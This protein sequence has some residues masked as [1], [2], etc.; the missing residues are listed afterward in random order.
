M[1]E[2]RCPRCG[3]WKARY[4]P[5]CGAQVAFVARTCLMCGSALE[6][7]TPPVRAR[8]ALPLPYRFVLS[9]LAILS[10]MAMGLILTWK[11]LP[12]MARPEEE[13]FGTGTPQSLPTATPSP[14]PTVT[15]S[16]RPTF[17]F[18]PPPPV[19][20]KVR[21]GE[22]LLFIAD[23][24]GTTV[25]AIIK[26]N[27]IEDPR[28]LIV[29]EEILIPIPTPTT[30]ASTPEAV[31]TIERE[32]LIHIVEP[33]ENPASIAAK[34]GT[35]AEALMEAND[36]TDP[37]SLRVGQELVIPNA[38]SGPTRVVEMAIHIVEPGDTLL[39]IAYRYD[40]TVEGIMAANDID[41]P[42]FLRVGQKLVIPLG[43]PT[44]VPT[45]TPQPTPTPTPGPP[46]AAPPLLFPADGQELHGGESVLLNWASVGFLSED[47]WYVVRLRYISPEGP[48][49]VSARTKAT[50]WLLPAS[51][52]P[53]AHVSSHLFRW[54]VTVVRQAEGED[55]LAVSPMSATRSFLWY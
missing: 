21:P 7:E 3:A 30:I 18:T 43:T 40:S 39:S 51:L 12:L 47:E 8:H 36:I 42:R 5:K 14:T 16:P 9:A 2:R 27:G 46:Y 44:P 41:D 13:A 24:Y 23:Y 19:I 1:R 20:H 26:A 33:G 52:R 34:Y 45:P 31:R 49:V 37:R 48:Q 38:S 54:N 22:T 50:S 53:P 15:P 28:W 17:T 25:E 32:P 11:V 6:E 55:G 35:T 4:C 10:V 29:G